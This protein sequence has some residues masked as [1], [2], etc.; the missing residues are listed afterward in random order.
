MN[1]Y[2]IIMTATGDYLPG[3][4]GTLNALRYYGYS[5]DVEFHL[6]YSPSPEMEDYCNA[7]KRRSVWPGFVP[8]DINGLKAAGY[9]HP[10]RQKRYMLH[11]YRWEYAVKELIDY[12]AVMIMD[13][14]ELIVN[15]FEEWFEFAATTNRLIMTN[16]DRSRLEKEDL[17]KRMLENRE[18]R[19]TALHSHPTFF[20]PAAH[21][22]LIGDFIGHSVGYSDQLNLS[23][24]L[25]RTGEIRG[26]FVMPCLL[27]LQNK[28]REV[29][30]L[31][32]REVAGKRYIA[33]FDT[34]DR[35]NMF[36]KPWWT[37]NAI[38]AEGR[39]EITAHNI[40]L[41]YDFYK[42]FNTELDFIIPWEWSWE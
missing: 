25:V 22:G 24:A 20:R 42:Y 28:S 1:K 29:I 33:L 31:C 15:N 19:G 5:E 14:D 11:F 23:R 35:I 40:K 32:Q 30:R 18:S 6:L 38:D 7:I 37:C 10:E 4:N 26:T 17:F 3:V 27:W 21:A 13:A 9:S 2:A 12:D 41:F 16:N 39:P 8:V 34:G 36:H